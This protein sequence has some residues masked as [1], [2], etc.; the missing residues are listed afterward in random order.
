MQV[1]EKKNEGLS[2]EFAITV[3]AEEIEARVTAR[4]EELNS[5]VNIPGFRPGK[6]PVALL[7][8]RYGQAVLGEVVEHAVAETS[9]QA[10]AERSLQP[11]MQPKIDVTSFEDGKDLEFTIAVEV[12]PTIEPAD[13]KGIELERLTAP[14]GDEEVDR[15]VAGMAGEFARSEPIETPRPAKDGDVVVLDFEGKIDGAIF[16]G[17]A[18]KDF[19]LTLGSGRFIPGFEDQLVGAN[20]GDAKQVKVTFPADYQ[21][22][23]LAGKDAVFDVTVKEIRE[24]VETKVDDDLAKSLGLDSLDDLRKNI[25]ERIENDYGQVSRGRMKRQLLDKLDEM[26]D[27]EVPPGMVEAETKSIWEQF[28]E[29]RR[30]GRLDQDE[31]DK[32][33]DELKAD[34]EKIAGRRVLLG[35]LLSEI[36]KKN[37]I[38]VTAEELNRVLLQEAQKYPGSERD[39]LEYYQKNEQAM[40][41]LRA[42]L[43]EEK[44]VDFIFEMA[45]ITEREITSEE[46]LAPPEEPDAGDAKKKPA[47][48]KSAKKSPK[49]S[50]KADKDDKS[51]AKSKSKAESNAKAGKT[52]AKGKDK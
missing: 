9:S 50:A 17:G 37:N 25:R 41:A 5:Q 2:R 19:N 40:A 44:V 42:P 12:M 33:E 32:D 18:A 7:R 47:T 38:E 16:E 1:T 21:S 26:H 15:A 14:V 45:D 35:L 39:I 30:E 31:M 36:G 20:A 11:A 23:E 24:P 29:A 46:L 49:A 52:A 22:E 51:K 28:E 48:K 4:L 3:P 8:Q 34:Y 6:V 27:F 43:F 10:I 13:L